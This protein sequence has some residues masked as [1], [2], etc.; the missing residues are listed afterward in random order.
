[1]LYMTFVNVPVMFYS[2]SFYLGENYPTKRKKKALTLLYVPAPMGENN[3]LEAESSE[4]HKRGTF[5]RHS[6]T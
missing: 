2:T 5:A 3:H 6:N 4:K 1:M